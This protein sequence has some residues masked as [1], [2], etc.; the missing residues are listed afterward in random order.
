MRTT[1][2]LPG[3]L[4]TLVSGCHEAPAPA[5]PPRPATAKADAA[6][7]ERGSWAGTGRRFYGV[8]DV[9]DPPPP[10]EAWREPVLPEGAPKLLEGFSFAAPI[11]PCPATNDIPDAAQWSAMHASLAAEPA[12]TGVF[13]VVALADGCARFVEY[14]RDGHVLRWELRRF[15]SGAWTPRITWDFDPDVTRP[16]TIDRFSLTVALNRFGEWAKDEVHR[17]RFTGPQDATYTHYRGEA[18]LYAE[19]PGA[20]PRRISSDTATYSCRTDG[21][22]HCD[23]LEQRAHDFFENPY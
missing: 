18:A 6:P 3:L 19:Q 8:R 5:P 16:T 13:E 20:P 1:R 10:S 9:V 17:K 12:P 2:W 15:R 11:T 22:N 21:S 23:R 14:R 7:G 4:L